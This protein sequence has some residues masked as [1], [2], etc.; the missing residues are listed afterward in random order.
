MPWRRSARTCSRR[1]RPSATATAPASAAIEARPR[2]ERGHAAVSPRGRDDRLL[3]RRATP[4]RHARHPRLPKGAVVRSFSSDSPRDTAW[5]ARGAPR[6]SA[7]PGL[8]RFI[9][10]MTYPGPV[11]AAGREPARPQ[12]TD[13]R[14]R[15]RTPFASRRRRHD[16]AAARPARR[17]ARACATAS[18]TAMMEAQLAHNLRVRDLVSDAI[19]RPSSCGAPR[20]RRELAAPP[21]RRWSRSSSRRRCATAG[22]GSSP[23]S[24]TCTA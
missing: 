19:A 24:T 16:H 15:A 3:A 12:W 8:N 7:R 18:R 2:R 5:C 11:D 21:D 6:L 4:A 13:G 9:W 17:S 1:A 14:A 23:T 10:D 22:P 20:A